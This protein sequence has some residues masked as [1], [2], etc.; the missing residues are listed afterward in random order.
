MKVTA[1]DVYPFSI[2]LRRPHRSAAMTTQRRAGA[3]VRVELDDG[4]VGWGEA[5]PL[6][7][8]TPETPDEA[9]AGL[10]AIVGHAVGRGRR[11]GRGAGRSS[12]LRRCR[13]SPRR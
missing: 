6:A 11:G 8:H 13:Q 12:R 10:R 9:V 4:A 7:G 5:A 3:W 1:A 2:E